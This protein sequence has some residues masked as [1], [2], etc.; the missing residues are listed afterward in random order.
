MTYLSGITL[1]P[2]STLQFC[3]FLLII[4]IVI[5][6]KSQKPLYNY[7]IKYI[8][9]L[10]IFFQFIIFITIIFRGIGLSFLDSESWGGFTYII[11]LTN[12]VFIF[13]I[14]R[15]VLNE[16]DWYKSIKYL[17][18]LSLLPVLIE[19][20]YYF[21]ITGFWNH[22]IPTPLEQVKEINTFGTRFQTANI[23]SQMIAVYAFFIFPRSL[24][25]KENKKK[26]TF[27]I[28]ISFFLAGLSGHRIAIISIS[29][30]L[31]ITILL[32]KRIEVKRS[33]KKVGII[34]ILVYVI[35]LLSVGVLPYSFQRSVSFLPFIKVEES[36][37]TDASG[38][39]DFRIL[40]WRS[41]IDVIPKYFIFGKGVT[42]S[43]D[44]FHWIEAT[45]PGSIE[46]FIITG[47]LHNGPLSLVISFGIFGFFI[48][49]LLFFCTIIDINKVN[50]KVW[51]L[52][53]LKSYFITIYS[54]FV[55]EVFVFIFIYGDLNKTLPFIFIIIA[56]IRGIIISEK[57]SEFIKNTI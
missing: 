15:A 11:L 20:M 36:A 46:D 42:F 28:M 30:F 51:S 34:L 45:E 8:K 37:L 10:L 4:F 49:M 27:L 19:I 40:I 33:I 7:Q 1:I 18:F 13:Y 12:I 25:R 57:N 43:S 9:P 3:Y 47:N 56:I 2:N 24:D 17:T 50:K 29:L 38:S 48:A 6:L 35:V 26:F 54:L 22:F 31:L 21:G 53:N 39:E 52:P 55:V 23:A 41:V 16:S 5:S 14:D 44:Y 32:N